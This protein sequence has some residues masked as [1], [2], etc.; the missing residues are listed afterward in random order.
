MTETKISGEQRTKLVQWSADYEAIAAYAGPGWVAT[1]PT[2]PRLM[3]FVAEQELAV[4]R[5]KNERE[6]L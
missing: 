4:S 2:R 1:D 6:D 5:L 3:G